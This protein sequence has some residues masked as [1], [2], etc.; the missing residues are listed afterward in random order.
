MTGVPK[1]SL[2]MHPFSISI[3]EHVPLNMGARRD[4]FQGG[5]SSGFSKG[6]KSS[7]TIFSPL[8]AKNILGD[9]WSP[10]LMPIPLK[11]LMTKR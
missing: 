3:D 8:K 6:G 7:K 9:P 10:F 2:A 4:F 1:L 5:A 11:L